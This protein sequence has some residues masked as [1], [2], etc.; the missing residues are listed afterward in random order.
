VLACA[1]CNKRKADRTPKQAR[2]KLRRRPARP[3]W[4]PLYSDHVAPIASW[5]KFVSEAYWS[6][7]LAE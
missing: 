3:V 6:V 7:P 5:S 1:A 2:M 4:K